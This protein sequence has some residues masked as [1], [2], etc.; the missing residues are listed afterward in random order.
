MEA[1]QHE[2][3]DVRSRSALWRR[4]PKYPALIPEKTLDVPQHVR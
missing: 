4:L 2:P 3:R 1:L